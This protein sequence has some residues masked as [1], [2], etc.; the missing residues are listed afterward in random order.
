MS[1]VSLLPAG[2]FLTLALASTSASA[3]DWER[4]GERKV[5]FMGDKDVIE[6]TAKEGR[7]NAIRL[8]VDEG[9]LEMY[10]V[11]VHFG[12]GSSFSPDTR[13]NFDQG[14]RSRI[15]DL[16]GD[17]R[18]INRVVFHYRS[19][20]K[21][22]GRATLTLFGRHPDAAPA[23]VPVAPPEPVPAPEARWEKLG[24]R[25]VKFVGDK[26]TI[27]VTYKEGRFTAIRF[28]IDDGDLEMFNVV[29]HFGNGEKFS[30]D[31]R[32]NFDQGSRSRVID[33]PGEARFV[34][35]VDFYYRS[36]IKKGRATIN[37]Y[38]RHP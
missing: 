14:T 1:P 22:K 33:L 36:K 37:L 7:F 21:L 24:Q 23:P 16:P 13:W 9:D 20:L 28:D 19:K 34:K 4:L 17:A 25:Q 3:G 38:G 15:I 30:P 5:A 18:F 8:D 32:W 2:L 11:V 27:P 35:K 10:N 12:D 29:V 26:D 6:V 31:T